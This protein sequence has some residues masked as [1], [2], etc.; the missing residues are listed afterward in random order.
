M[1]L[2]NERYLEV[3]VDYL[4]YMDYLSIKITVCIYCIYHYSYLLAYDWPFSDHEGGRH[5]RKLSYF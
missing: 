2:T 4:H 1:D 3:T 5:G